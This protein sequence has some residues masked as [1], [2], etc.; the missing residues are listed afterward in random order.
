MMDEVIYI[1]IDLGGTAIKMGMVNIDGELVKE[2]ERPT[3]VSEGHRKVVETFDEMIALL[4]KETD[5]DW[6]NIKGIGI[7]IPG[8]VNIETGNVVEAVNLQWNDVQIK[9]ILETKW[10]VP[11]SVDN[12]ANTAALGEMWV[13][14]GEA[15]KH[16]LC[17]TIGTGI[18][19]GIIINRDIYHGA[20]G[21]AGEIGHFIVKDQ[22]GKACNC[23]KTGCLEAEASATAIVK[24][25]LEEVE[26]KSSIPLMEVYDRT[27]QIT[28]KTIVELA[29]ADDPVCKRIITE[30][31]QLL[32]KTLSKFCVLLNPEKIIIG[33]GVSYAGD[34]LLNPMNEAFKAHALEIISENTPIVRAELGN[35]AGMIGAAWLADKTFRK[36]EQGRNQ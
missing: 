28:A 14:A 5:F 10:G 31:G 24:Q 3:P 7:G 21:I 36:Y 2:I 27:G 11:V 30:L 22:G 15:N 8:F 18:G 4:L 6:E 33:G 23:G 20:N 16:I 1:G 34:L 32:G 26:K 13:G 9:E 17:L 29:K 35:K 12:D 19:G 25:A